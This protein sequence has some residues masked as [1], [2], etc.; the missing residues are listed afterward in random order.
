MP[1]D[2]ERLSALV[3]DGDEAVVFEVRGVPRPQPR[4]RF[5]GPGRVVSTAGKAVKAW[6]AAVVRE[7]KAVRAERGP[8]PKASAL[9]VSLVFTFVGPRGGHGRAHL[10]RPDVDN[11]A[12]L[13]MDAVIEAGLIHDDALIFALAARKVWGA[14]GGVVVRLDAVGAK[15]EGFVSGGTS[16]LVAPGW[17]R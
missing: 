6:K 15:S 2:A 12:K 3:D 16:A 10:Q 17:L 1:T 9:A 13:V 4:P 7:A 11:L 14:T 8:L 5:V